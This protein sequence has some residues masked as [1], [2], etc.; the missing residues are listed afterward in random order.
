MH[1]RI[2]KIDSSDAFRLKQK[3]YSG[4]KRTRADLRD[5]STNGGVHQLSMPG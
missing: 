2:P 5:S 3:S 1:R 4:Q